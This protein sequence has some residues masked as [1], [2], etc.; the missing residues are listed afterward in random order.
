MDMNH[1]LS[2]REVTDLAISW[3]TISLAF[4]IAVSGLRL[5]TVTGALPITLIAVGTGFIFHELAHKYV[6]L[7]YK[8]WAEFRMWTMGLVIA[9]VGAV[10]GFVFAAPGAVY[11]YAEHL[12]K[13]KNAFIS[14]AGPL[15]NLGIAVIFWLIWVMRP[16]DLL[17]LVAGYGLRI[18]LWLGFFNMIPFMPLDGAKVWRYSPGLWASLFVPLG[19]LIFFP[20]ALAGILPLPELF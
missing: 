17:G 2:A 9:L 4:A 8:A 6:A 14:I 19:I 10:V 12:S 16:G 11:I 15:M 1:Q 5:A 7:H 20:H 3:I 18:N 13:K